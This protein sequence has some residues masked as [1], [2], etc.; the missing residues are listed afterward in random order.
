VPPIV[1]DWLA[2]HTVDALSIVT[3]VAYATYMRGR[4]DHARPL[5]SKA[6][7][8]DFFNGIALAPLALMFFAAFSDEILSLLVKASGVTIAAASILALFA[9]LEEPPA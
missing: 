9:I 2:R 7:G 6:T 3:G 8:L 1:W 4:L 5:I